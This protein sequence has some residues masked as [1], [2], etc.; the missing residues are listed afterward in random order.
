VS[1]VQ[2]RLA[3]VHSFAELEGEWRALEAELPAPSFFQSWSWV[4]CLAEE[5]YPDPVLLRAEAGGRLLGLALFNR[6]RRRLHLAESG[7]AGMDAPFIEH[8]APLAHEAALGPLLRAAW[9]SGARR[10]VLSGVPPALPPSAGGVALRW[11]ERLAPR[12]ELDAVRAAG[13]DWLAGRSGNSRYQIRRS[14][15]AYAAGGPL[16]LHRAGD[17]EQ[18]LVWLGALIGLHEATWRA[19]GK[20]GAFAT[21]FLRRFHEALIRRA[22]PRD[23]L[24]MLRIEAGGKDVGYL[25]NFRMRGHVHAYQ[26]G[27]DHAGA[28]THEKP[29]LTCHALAIEH[30]LARGDSIY[31]FLAGADRY[32]RSLANAELPLIWAEMVPRWSVLGLAA[33]LRGVLRR[34]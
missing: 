8:N 33:R 30:A 1:A 13:G 10:L 20:P 27:L 29:G 5:R 18:A 6:R 21:P 16:R 3:P 24:D 32:K 28:G 14:A 34:G 23:E 22:A 17:A 31:D 9:G 4:G 11:Q 2:V 7:E 19:R 25:Y 15:R 26:S 12:V